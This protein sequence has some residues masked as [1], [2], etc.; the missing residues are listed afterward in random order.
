MSRGGREVR[1]VSCAGVTG[2]A[3]PL[4]PLLLGLLSMKGRT[5]KR[6]F[7][8][9]LKALSTPKL[10]WYNAS[11]M[12]STYFNPPGL[13]GILC[14]RAEVNTLLGQG[15]KALADLERGL[16]LADRPK[17]VGLRR[18]LRLKCLF[19]KIR[20]FHLQGRFPEMRE[21]A[22]GALEVSR[23]HQDLKGEGNS[24][25]QIGLT[26]Y[27]L[28]EL[29]QA[30]NYYQR[31]LEISQEIGDRQ[32]EVRSL[33]NLGVVHHDLGEYERALEYYQRS[34]RVG[35]EIG[36]RLG[37]AASLNN[38]GAAYCDLGEYE[39]AQDY[40]QRSVKIVREIGDRQGE[41]ASQNN[42]GIMHSN[43]GNYEQALD[44]YQRSLKIRREIGDRQGEALALNNLSDVL[45]ESGDY[46]KS[47]EFFKQGEILAQE[48]G[49]KDLWARALSGLA[50]LYLH[51]EELL[52]AEEKIDQL[53]QAA[54]EMN[55]RDLKGFAH[56][57]QARLHVKRQERDLARE[58]FQEAIALFKEI[59]EELELGKACYYYWQGLKE[60]GD[61]RE[62][63]WY[64]VQAKEIFTRLKAKGWLEKMEANRQP[65]ERA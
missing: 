4:S 6:L 47:E 10:F 57:L 48:L 15:D 36:D 55:S 41:A 44:C 20:V 7:F 3:A 26:H 14:S 61:D 49:V 50:S 25:H 32:G 24:L 45:L 60:M 28:G 22:E 42:M 19:G 58:E 8:N 27:S 54:E 46:Q 21:A 2:L 31:S 37:E 39:R 18:T 35:H 43:L 59:R 33:N 11:V 64:G 30:L 52:L 53:R 9:L 40:Y 51:R 38:L 65:R 56:R 34:Q 1:T 23:H 12:T 63:E 62:S 29:G 17:E 13:V 16:G 5:T